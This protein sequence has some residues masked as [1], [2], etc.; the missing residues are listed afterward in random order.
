MQAEFS[1][2]P[3]ERFVEIEVIKSEVGDNFFYLISDGD[4]RAALV[5]P[6]DGEGAVRAVRRRE[7]ELV[8]ILN[9]HFHP[10]HVAGNPRV[11]RDFPEAEVIAGEIDAGAIDDQLAGGSGRGV[12]RR[13]RGEER[14]EIGELTL[15]VLETPGHTKGHVSFQVGEHLFSGDTIFAGGAGNCRFGGDPGDL[16]RT[17]RDVLRSLPVETRIYPG[18]DYAVNNAK[19]VL[20][21]E[22]EQNEARQV[23]EQAE[24]AARSGELFLTTL[25]REQRYN[26]F[27]RFDDPDLL[28]RLEERKG[29]ELQAERERSETE[30]E[31][32]FRCL[33]TLRNDW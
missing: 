22:P 28:R 33:R 7:E 20:S 19:F 9:T 26:P 25:G 32:L 30:E 13:V 18:H 15:V 21:L 31:A 5:D 4:G 16:F 2:L 24:Q 27:L 17:F 8:A 23:L 14:I 10:D 3:E 6:V 29:K 11:L 12:D 1:R